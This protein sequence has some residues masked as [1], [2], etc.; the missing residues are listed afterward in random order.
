MSTPYSKRKRRSTKPHT[1]GS[2]YG[3]RNKRRRSENEDDSI[4]YTFLPER[5]YFSADVSDEVEDELQDLTGETWTVFRV[6]PMHNFEYSRIR[7]KQYSRKMKENLTV[8]L[9]Q[10][11]MELHYDVNFSVAEGIS[12]TEHDNEAVR[13]TVN[14]K[15]QMNSR[16]TDTRTYYL[17]F[18]VCRG[19]PATMQENS[20]VHLPVLLCKGRVGIINSVHNILQKFFECVIVPFTLTQED[21]TWICALQSEE[22]ARGRQAAVMEMVFT[23]PRLSVKNVINFKLPLASLKIL[24]KC[25]PHIL[26]RDSF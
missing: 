26:R 17:G 16:N 12:A 11:K 19:A 15:R 8:N 18:L 23:A 13:I 10:A 14:A 9:P 2:V 5:L 3:I 25:C 20:S 7:L 24:W 1:P 6:S 21:L 22:V 4:S